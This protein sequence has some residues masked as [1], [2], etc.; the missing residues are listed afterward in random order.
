M[1]YIVFGSKAGFEVPKFYDQFT[2]PSGVLVS[3]Y[4]SMHQTG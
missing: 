3:A 4:G 2:V 1:W